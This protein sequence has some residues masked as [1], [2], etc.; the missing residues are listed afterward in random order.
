MNAVNINKSHIGNIEEFFSGIGSKDTYKY[1]SEIKGHNENV[2]DYCR[3]LE[4]IFVKLKQELEPSDEEA[5]KRM[6]E[7]KGYLCNNQLGIMQNGLSENGM[8]D[9]YKEYSNCLQQS[10]E[11]LYKKYYKD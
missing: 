5:R 10:I 4:H 3:K 9:F 6:L 11:E 1:F 8:A 2:V 7:V